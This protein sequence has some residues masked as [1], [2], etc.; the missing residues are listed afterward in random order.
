MIIHFINNFHWLITYDSFHELYSVHLRFLYII[1]LYYTIQ[2]PIFEFM[3]IICPQYHST[4]TIASTRTFNFIRA[5]AVL[6]KNPS[7]G[8]LFKQRRGLYTCDARRCPTIL[9]ICS[10]AGA[11]ASIL[12][13]VYPQC[14]N[15]SSCT[16]GVP[17]YLSC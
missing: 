7:I 10:G 13:A 6:G 11:T 16:E 2:Y 15:Y 3:Y 5:I 8:W 4:L 14:I 1:L 12:Q 9:I 17:A